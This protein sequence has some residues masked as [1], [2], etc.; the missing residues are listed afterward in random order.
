M[1]D[2]AYP[3]TSKRRRLPDEGV[4]EVFVANEQSAHPVDTARWQMLAERVL[5]AE[6]IRGDAELSLLFVDE[7]TIT[8]LNERFMGAEEPTDVLAFPLEDDA[9]GA[10]RWPDNSDSGPRALRD[11]GVDPPLLLGDVVICPQVASVNAPTHAGTYDDEIALLVVHGI[12]HVLGMDHADPEEEAEMQ[13]KERSL[14]ERFHRS[15]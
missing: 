14:L 7:Q 12:L 1:T 5:D 11:E 13:A 4:L 6:G 3:L 9:I 8:E 2:P 10:G 15:S